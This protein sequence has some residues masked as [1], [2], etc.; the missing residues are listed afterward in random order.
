M[1]VFKKLFGK[2]EKKPIY[3]KE[4]MKHIME[5]ELDLEP[6]FVDLTLAI[7]KKEERDRSQEEMIAVIN[8]WG[9]EGRL[10]KDLE[11][12]SLLSDVYLSHKEWVKEKAQFHYDVRQGPRDRESM[13]VFINNL[14]EP[15]ISI[16]NIDMKHTYFALWGEMANVFA[17]VG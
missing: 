14:G 6:W 1:G 7:V 17:Q 2:T 12:E 11:E 3:Y 10:S 13:D 16:T 5:N 9:D 8:S 4:S 15:F